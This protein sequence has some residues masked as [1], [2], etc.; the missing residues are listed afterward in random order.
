L[1]YQ[2]I[3]HREHPEEMTIF[4]CE[5][6]SNSTPERPVLQVKIATLFSGRR[7]ASAVARFPAHRPGNHLTSSQL[8]KIARS[9]SVQCRY[10][11]R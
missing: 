3:E 2:F 10:S 8:I 11:R 7:R 4:V 5:A 9:S 6:A 1:P